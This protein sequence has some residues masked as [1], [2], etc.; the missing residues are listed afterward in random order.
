[1][2]ERGSVTQSGMSEVALATQSRVQRKVSISPCLII[3]LLLISSGLGSTVGSVGRGDIKGAANGLS[4]VGTSAVSNV[5]SIGGN[6]VS[7]VSKTGGSVV[8]QVNKGAGG[9]SLSFS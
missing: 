6:L 2:H 7:D 3:S 5:G 8:G 4:S 1:M 9:M